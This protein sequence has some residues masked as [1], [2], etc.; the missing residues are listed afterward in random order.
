MYKLGWFGCMVGGKFDRAPYDFNRTLIETMCLSCRPTFY[1]PSY[2]KLVVESRQFLLPH[3]RLALTFWWW[4]CSIS[5]RYLAQESPGLSCMQWF[6]WSS[7]TDRQ[8]HR[9]TSDDSIYRASLTSR[10]KN[11]CRPILPMPWR[12]WLGLVFVASI[13]KFVSNRIDI[14]L[15]IHSFIHSL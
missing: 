11:Y 4:S 6:A 12:Y 9:Q 3:V 14:Y 7:V 2:S 15:F 13:F 1:R 5:P 8:T 10:G